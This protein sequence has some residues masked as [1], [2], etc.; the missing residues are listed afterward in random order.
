MRH[1]VLALILAACSSCER[2]PP[3]P[4]PVPDAGPPPAS[5]ADACDRL[6]A[7]GCKAGAL[8][9]DTFDDAGEC[10]G[11]MTCAQA[12]ELAPQAYPDPACVL[13]L[14]PLGEPCAEVDRVCR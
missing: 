9:C 14:V 5:C 1:C 13:E 3:A 8:V 2:P 10:V 11:R 6:I 4:Q 12:C 7:W